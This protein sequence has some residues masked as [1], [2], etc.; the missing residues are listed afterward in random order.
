MSQSHTMEKVR[1]P[2]GSTWGC[3]MWTHS[4]LCPHARRLRRLSCNPNAGSGLGTKSGCPLLSSSTGLL[5]TGG[6]YW[7]T[8]ELDTSSLF[9]M[10]S[11]PPALPWPSSRVVP[12]RGRPTVNVSGSCAWIL[13]CSFVHSSS[14]PAFSRKG[15]FVQTMSSSCPTSRSSVCSPS[16]LE[17]S[18]HVWL[19]RAPSL[20]E[21]ACN[22]GRVPC[23]VESWMWPS[24]ITS[25]VDEN[26]FSWMGK[27]RASPLP[28]FRPW[29]GSLIT[30]SSRMLCAC[31]F[32]HSKAAP[33]P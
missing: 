8:V 3:K 5:C 32:S 12:T 9:M 14:S 17:W 33:F 2:S 11:L 6:K 19:F 27:G 16:A 30:C 20:E 26:P 22:F 4:A 24:D 25:K 15:S 28:E 13:R 31:P 18:L 7:T 23:C 1:D 29:L 21:C 10:Q